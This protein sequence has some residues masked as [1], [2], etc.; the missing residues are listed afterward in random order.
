MVDAG[1]VLDTLPGLY[2]NYRG[3]IELAAPTV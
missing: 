2:S 1:L 3:Y